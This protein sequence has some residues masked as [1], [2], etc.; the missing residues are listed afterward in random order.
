MSSNE[1]FLVGVDEGVLEGTVGV[2]K[3]KNTILSFTHFLKVNKSLC[4]SVS[5]YVIVKV[6]VFKIEWHLAEWIWPK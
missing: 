5:C 6:S 2:H 3:T 1:T 4:F